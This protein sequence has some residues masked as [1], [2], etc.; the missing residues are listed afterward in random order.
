MACKNY[1]LTK[2]IEKLTEIWKRAT[3]YISVSKVTKIIR[4]E[5]P[6][7]LFNLVKK[8]HFLLNKKSGVMANS[9]MYQK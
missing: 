8:N 5:Q 7:P 2:S 3:P 6:K 9:L 1:G 4:D